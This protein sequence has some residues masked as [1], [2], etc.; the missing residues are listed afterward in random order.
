MK[1]TDRGSATI[2]SITTG[3]EALSLP[4]REV[5]CLDDDKEQVSSE[6]LGK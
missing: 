2:M 6:E 4:S 5:A 3:L 1:E